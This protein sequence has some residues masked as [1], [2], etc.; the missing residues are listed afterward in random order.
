MHY[1]FAQLFG[2]GFAA[3]VALRDSLR[4]PV[5]CYNLG[6]IDRNVRRT[7]LKVSHGIATL[8]HQLTD[9]LI[10]LSDCA[11]GVIDEAALQ[12]FPG[13]TEPGGFSRFQRYDI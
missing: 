9:Q 3:L 11:L 8:Q 5:M 4:R 2:I 1:R 10:G 6:V 7:T 12:I 13:L